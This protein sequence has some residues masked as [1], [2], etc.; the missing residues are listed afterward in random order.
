[1]PNHF[2]QADNDKGVLLW[3]S[4]SP[5]FA[6]SY[7]DVTMVASTK[8]RSGQG[9]VLTRLAHSVVFQLRSW[10]MK[11]T[12]YMKILNSFINHMSNKL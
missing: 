4:K 11:Q 12:L 2:Q 10:L 5:Y 9:R 1:M 8:N 3:F 7:D 6:G